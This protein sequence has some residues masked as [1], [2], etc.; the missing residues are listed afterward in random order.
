[1]KRLDDFIREVRQGT[2]A[3][4]AR[5][6]IQVKTKPEEKLDILFEMARENDFNLTYHELVEEMERAD[7]RAFQYEIERAAEAGI[8]M[9]HDVRDYAWPFSWLSEVDIR[10]Q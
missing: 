1:M 7:A 3:D 10:K 8:E 4:E 6:R 9:E 2:L 5:K